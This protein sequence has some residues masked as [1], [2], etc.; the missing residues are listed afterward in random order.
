MC[1][2]SLNA[3]NYV[4]FMPTGNVAPSTTIIQS[5]DTIVEFGVIIPGMYETPINSL[6][7]VNVKEHVRLDSVGYPEIP[8]VSFLVAIPDCDRIKDFA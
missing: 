5:N 4:E 7:H 8:V 6:N 2:Y 3:Q 1:V